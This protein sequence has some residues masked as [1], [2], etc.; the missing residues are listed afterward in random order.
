MQAKI[1][2][3]G[4]LVITCTMEEQKELRRMQEED[5][6]AFKTNWTM[7]Q[8]FESLIANSEYQWI[9]P[10]TIGALTDAPILG[11]D[12]ESADVDAWGFMDYAITSPQEELLKHRKCIFQNGN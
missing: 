1:K 7:D 11:I 9:A 2:K 10:E 4:N 3:N 6:D 5:P 8:V 12:H